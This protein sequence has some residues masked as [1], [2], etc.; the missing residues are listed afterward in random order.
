LD[1]L[2][3]TFLAHDTSVFHALVFTAIAFIVLDRPKYLGA[4]KPISFWLK[5]P[6]VNGLR[7]FDFT[8]RPFPDFLWRGKR[9][10]HRVKA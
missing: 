3:A 9:N 2:Y 4:E 1:Y 5:G 7:F 10:P 8:K 6:I